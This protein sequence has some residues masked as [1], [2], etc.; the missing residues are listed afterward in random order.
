M[1]EFWSDANIFYYLETWVANPAT[2]YTTLYLTDI[3]LFQRQITTDAFKI[4][5]GLDMSSSTNPSKP[6][7]QYQI[8]SD[9]ITKIIKAF[10]DSL[11]AFLDGLVLLA[12]EESPISVGK[13]FTI[14]D[15]STVAGTNPLDLL[16][17]SETVC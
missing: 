13:Q 12:S 14:P 8:T 10:L 1:A 7:K 11:Y 5:G 15:V 16:D 2:P 3:Q 6:I 9:F 17:I 4:A